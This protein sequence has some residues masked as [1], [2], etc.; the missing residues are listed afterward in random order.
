[1][2]VGVLIPLKALVHAGWVIPKQLWFLLNTDDEN[3]LDPERTQLIMLVVIRLI[4]RI[5]QAIA[6]VPHAKRYKGF[7]NSWVVGVVRCAVKVQVH[8]DAYGIHKGIR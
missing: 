2:L 6:K 5:H 1:M 7:L 4:F 3:A 8:V